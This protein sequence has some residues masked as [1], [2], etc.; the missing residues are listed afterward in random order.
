VRS[1]W[2]RKAGEA[3]S[4]GERFSKEG[5]GRQCGVGVGG[6]DRHGRRGWGRYG[7]AGLDEV[8]PDKAQQAMRGGYDLERRRGAWNCRHGESACGRRV[9]VW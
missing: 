8:W 6:T 1:G 5:Y 2:D 9:M 3:S 7:L 4:D